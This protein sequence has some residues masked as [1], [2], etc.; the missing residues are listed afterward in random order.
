MVGRPCQTY[1]ML[2][3]NICPEQSLLLYDYIILRL[4]YIFYTQPTR[5]LS[6]KILF[7]LTCLAG[8]A[9]MHPIVHTERTSNSCSTRWTS[10][11]LFGK[12]QQIG[13]K[14]DETML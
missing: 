5:I 6:L 2:V 1:W 14:P 3:R 11:M 10:L 12:I 8:R 13:T 7:S 4:T 9:S